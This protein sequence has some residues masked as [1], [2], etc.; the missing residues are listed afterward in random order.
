MIC[1]HDSRTILKGER[2]SCTFY[3]A[4]DDFIKAHAPAP[5]NL[6]EDEAFQFV[7]RQFLL[8]TFE[9]EARRFFPRYWGS[10]TEVEIS[11]RRISFVRAALHD[12]GGGSHFGE[13]EVSADLNLFLSRTEY[14]YV[15]T[16]D[17][18]SAFG[19]KGDLIPIGFGGKTTLQDWD[20]LGWSSVKGVP[21]SGPVRLDEPLEW[22]SVP[23]KVTTS[24]PVYTPTSKKNSE[25][26][27]KGE[28][29][30]S[31]RLV[32]GRVTKFEVENLRT[33]E[34]HNRPVT[35]TTGAIVT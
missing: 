14:S 22:K 31:F 12:V 15:N 4:I 2:S 3:K 11:D 21:L 29:T 35:Q 1:I 27:L 33:A 6:T 18:L 24:M 34:I 23:Y 26:M 30:V 9:I 28:M 19:V 5:K 20:E 10:D 17:T 8:D 32:S 25:T 16:I 13:M 7:S